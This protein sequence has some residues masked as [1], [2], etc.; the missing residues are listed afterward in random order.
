MIAL[1][2]AE[3]DSR[4]IEDRMYRAE[5]MLFLVCRES[6]GYKNDENYTEMAINNLKH[7]EGKIFDGIFDRYIADGN[8]LDEALSTVT[9]GF[10]FSTDEIKQKIRARYEKEVAK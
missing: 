3:T 8:T 9:D 10:I 2:P 4:K 5:K 1:I 7:S 6:M